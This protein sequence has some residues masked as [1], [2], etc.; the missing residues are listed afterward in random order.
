[1]SYR[2]RVPMPVQN[3]EC[4]VSYYRLN[5]V[6]SLVH[7]RPYRHSVPFG[8]LIQGWILLFGTQIRCFI[9]PPPNISTGLIDIAKIFDYEGAVTAKSGISI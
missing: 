8:T 2:C 7:R 1:M 9:M 6:E 3:R 5:T 4:A